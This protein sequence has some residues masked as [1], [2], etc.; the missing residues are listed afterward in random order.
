MSRYITVSAKIDTKLKEKITKYNISVSKV[1]KKAL[2]EEVKR[3]EEE[4]LR[5]M[6]KEASRILSKVGRENIIRFIREG[7]EER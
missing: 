3:R 1:I 5:E 2:E 6:L 4:E 7:R